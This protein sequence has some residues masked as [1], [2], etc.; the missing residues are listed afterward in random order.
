MPN[1][2]TGATVSAA[3]LQSVDL[4]TAMMMV[5][6]DR[7]NNLEV[8]L[9]GQLQAVAQRN[10][11]IASLNKLMTDLRA[12]RPSGSDPEKWGN[13][14]ANQQAGRDMYARVQA[15]GLT[16]PDAAGGDAVNEPGTNIYDA[17]QKTY[18]VWIEEIKGKIDSASNSQQM[19]ML[20]L[21]SLSNKRNEAFEIMT[22]FVK[23]MSDSRGSIV[24][25]MR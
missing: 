19:D 11:D 21:Q 6:S 8:Q 10:Q 9:K 25:N 22:N 24:G 12:M 4:E 23:K 14:G 2:I 16:I 18:D 7:A 5:Q 1:A 15:A 20:R 17:K 13:M 3:Q